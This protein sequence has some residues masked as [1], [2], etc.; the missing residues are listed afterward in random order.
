[1][2]SEA[3]MISLLFI[4]GI[5]CATCISSQF[6][7]KFRFPSH[8]YIFQKIPLGDLETFSVENIDDTI[9]GSKTKRMISERRTQLT[10]LNRLLKKPVFNFAN[11][12]RHH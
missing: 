10:Q 3:S 4:I 9:S 8:F 11:L 6:Y 5:S 2:P 7:Y 12:F 1:M